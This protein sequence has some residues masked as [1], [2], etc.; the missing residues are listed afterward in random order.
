MFAPSDDDKPAPLPAAAPA[1]TAPAAAVSTPS[2]PAASSHAERTQAAVPAVVPAAEAAADAVDYATWP[3]SE[4]KR[5]LTEAGC[6]I[7][8]CIDKDG[9]VE[10]ARALDAKRASHAVPAGFV[11]DPASGYF[12][13]TDTGWY[14]HQESHMYYKDGKWFRADGQ[15]GQ[16]AEVT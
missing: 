15:T 3:V 2:V 11:L 8:V 9:L 16:L 10:K 14:F 13:N 7:S 5:L 12:M 6:D 4:L 1:T